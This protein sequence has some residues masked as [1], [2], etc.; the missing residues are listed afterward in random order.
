M[1]QKST[2]TALKERNERIAEKATRLNM[3]TMLDAAN[4]RITVYRKMLAWLNDPARPAPTREDYDL[5]DE[6]VLAYDRTH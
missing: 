4:Q 3:Q 6:D 1:Y 5:V 2:I